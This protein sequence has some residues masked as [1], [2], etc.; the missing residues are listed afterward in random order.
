M[1]PGNPP[2]ISLVF[3]GHFLLRSALCNARLSR[4]PKAN[5]GFLYPPTTRTVQEFAQTPKRIPTCPTYLRAAAASSDGSNEEFDYDP[6]HDVTSRIAVSSDLVDVAELGSSTLLPDST[7][8]KLSPLTCVQGVQDLGNRL[9]ESPTTRG[10]RMPSTESRSWNAA[11]LGI[12]R[13]P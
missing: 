8:P 12:R 3:P 2:Y 6:L 7:S 5:L 13:M 10:R 1:V 4:L 11:A 9:H